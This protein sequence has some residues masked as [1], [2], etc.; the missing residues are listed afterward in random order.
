MFR[1][2]YVGAREEQMPIVLTMINKRTRTPIPAVAFLVNFIKYLF[3]SFLTG[4]PFT[5]L[6]IVRRKCN[7]IDKLHPSQL[8]VGNRRGDGCAFL[9]SQKDANSPKAYQGKHIFFINFQY[10]FNIILSGEF[11]I[12]RNFLCRMRCTGHHSDHGKPK[13]HW[14]SN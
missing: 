1:L 13:G 14:Y 6:L 2:F 12:P 3:K 8:L 9:P 4:F 10:I 7:N 11:D 5:R